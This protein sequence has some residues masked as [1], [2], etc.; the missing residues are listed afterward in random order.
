MP[1]LMVSPPVGPA[2]LRG[3][4]A[5]GAWFLPTPPLPQGNLWDR[6]LT[7]SPFKS[8]NL[9]ALGVPGGYQNPA[10][11]SALQKNLAPAIIAQ[12]PLHE[13]V[14]VLLGCLSSGLRLP[15]LSSLPHPCLC[16]HSIALLFSA[17]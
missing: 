15:E 13:Q 12:L 14:E 4:L 1:S 10:D 7:N 2:L 17:R 11:A 5:S 9:G 3:L 8:A 6:N 16:K